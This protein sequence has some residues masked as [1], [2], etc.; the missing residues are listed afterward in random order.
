MFGFAAGENR[1]L[2]PFRRAYNATADKPLSPGDFYQWLTPLFVAY[3][4][5]LVQRELDE[6]A[7]PHT[8]S[9][10]F[11]RFRDVTVADATILRIHRFLRE[12]YQGL[13]EEQTEAK[14][15]LLHNVTDQT[16]DRD[17]QRYS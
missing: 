14:L 4:H 6:V 17:Q 15:H 5:D 1:T 2:A 11:D 7:V 10:E 13:C 3:L 9:D 16:I 8:V 12:E